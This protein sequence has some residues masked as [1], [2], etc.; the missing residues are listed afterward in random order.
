MNIKKIRNFLWYFIVCILV[1]EAFF[2]RGSIV[3]RT[4]LIL[5]LFA[6]IA[7][8]IIEIKIYNKK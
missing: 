8:T 2:E 6:L 1:I 3:R 7:V 5:G 4:F